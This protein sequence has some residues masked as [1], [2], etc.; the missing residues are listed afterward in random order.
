MSLTEDQRATL[1]VLFNSS[2]ELR[3]ALLR[4]AD[5]KLICTVCEVVHNFLRGNINIEASDKKKLSKH[6]ILFRTVA[7]KGKSWKQK[8]RIIQKGGGF[9][10]KLLAP[11][12]GALLGN[13]L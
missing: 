9:I 5:K 6:K 4:H 7:S 8:R 10:I 1:K 12:L 3:K 13:L 11:I 2:P